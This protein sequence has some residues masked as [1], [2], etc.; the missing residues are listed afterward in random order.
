MYLMKSQLQQTKLNCSTLWT[1]AY[2]WVMS[3]TIDVSSKYICTSFVIVWS[4]LEK[5]WDTATQFTF[6][7][8]FSFGYNSLVMMRA[9][10]YRKKAKFLIHPGAKTKCV[11]WFGASNAFGE[12]LKMMQGLRVRRTLRARSCTSQLWLSQL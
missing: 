3:D 2:N 12:L 10:N 5:S 11:L 7:L 9:Q 1:V 4:I 8:Q 6:S